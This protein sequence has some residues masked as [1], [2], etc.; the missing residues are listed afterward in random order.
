MPKNKSQKL[1]YLLHNLSQSLH[2][3]WLL[4]CVAFSLIRQLRKQSNI[5]VR[6]EHTTTHD[7]LATQRAM[8]IIYF[9]LLATRRRYALD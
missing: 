6:T 4:R 7:L 3:R 2:F 1:Y 5:Y 9:L 8:R